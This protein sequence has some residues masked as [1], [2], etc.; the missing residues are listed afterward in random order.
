MLLWLF[1][2]LGHYFPL[3]LVFK[4]LTLRAMLSVL[5]AFSLSLLLGPMVIERLRALKYGQAIRTDGPQSHLVKTGTPTM[6]GILILG[7][8]GISTLLWADLRN[9]YVWIV[10][11]VMVIFGAVGW[12]DDWLKIRYKNPDGLAARKKYFWTSVGSLGAGIALYQIAIHMPTIAQTH[13]MVDLL[14]PV[15]K[16]LSIPFSAVPF[17]LAFIAFTYFVIN[18]ASNSVNLTDGLDGL[19]IMPVV[20]VAAGLGTFAYLTGDARYAAYLHIPYISFS[21]ELVIICTA[22]AGAGMGFLWFNAHPA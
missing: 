17:G 3:F 4:Y 6:G 9:P 7:A 8:I 12:M 22:I 21:S 20:L 2:Q 14:I 19:A 13:A 18:G 11:M 16:N 5:T 10:L 1:A 15:F